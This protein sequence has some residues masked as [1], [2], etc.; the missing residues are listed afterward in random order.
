MWST[1]ERKRFHG[2][3][4]RE[5]F[6]VIMRPL[7]DGHAIQLSPWECYVS[8]SPSILARVCEFIPEVT[9]NPALV[10]STAQDDREGARRPGGTGQSRLAE[11]VTP[12]GLIRHNVEHDA[13]PVPSP[14]RTPQLLLDARLF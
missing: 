5:I 1:C 3:R 14:L 12:H 9:G 10:P 4:K 11:N 8:S 2:P 13:D 6:A 7:V